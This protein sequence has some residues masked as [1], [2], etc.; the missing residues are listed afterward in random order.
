MSRT[1]RIIIAILIILSGV[2]VFCYPTIASYVNDFFANR[3]VAEYTEKV[4]GYDEEELEKELAM[5]YAY[6]QSLPFA[7]PADPFSG[8]QISNF[9]GTEFEDFD[10]VQDGAMI[11]YVEIPTIDVFL[12][13]YYGT[14]EEVLDKSLGLVENTSLPVGGP[15]T[16]SVISGHSGMA[17]R[18]LFT[19]LNQMEEGDLF[20][21]HVL[22]QDFAYK[23][24]QIKVVLPTET[25][26][27]MIEAEH[28]YITLL[29][30]TP[31]GINDHRL[32]VRGERIDYDF[33]SEEYKDISL[34]DQTD[35]RL[36]IAG[37][38]VG[39]VVIIMVIILGAGKRK[40]RKERQNASKT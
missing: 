38:M 22:S 4:S 34:Q 1:K 39:I 23:V 12:P 9:T 2:L 35:R 16:H 14:S 24:N 11:G 15:G 26:D 13:V 37:A 25:E 19:D 6:N 17:S 36:L 18:K 30:C 28:D 8:S 3:A 31:L 21:I 32:L 33:S 5:A 40:K 27:L 7:Y 10:L 29:T 20:F